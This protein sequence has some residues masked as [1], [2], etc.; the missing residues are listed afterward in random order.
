MKSGFLLL[1]I[2]LLQSYLHVVAV[3]LLG[4]GARA[5]AEVLDK[6]ASPHRGPK[7]KSRNHEV[8]SP[9]ASKMSGKELHKK[10]QQMKLRAHSDS[11]LPLLFPVLLCCMPC[12]ATASLLETVGGSLELRS[13]DQLFDRPFGPPRLI[14][15]NATAMAQCA[16]VLDNGTPTTNGEVPRLHFEQL[17]VGL[18]AQCLL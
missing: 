3:G 2:L 15:Q 10:T 5:E 11:C 1:N 14:K 4:L 6:D 9:R 18:P 13:T 12:F 7:N 17:L 16:R 8:S